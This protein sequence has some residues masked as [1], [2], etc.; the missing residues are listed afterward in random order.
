M[1][2]RSLSRRLTTCAGIVTVLA[3]VYFGG[4][5]VSRYFFFRE[6]DTQ[7]TRLNTAPN[8]LAQW[9][10]EQIDRGFFN[11]TLTLVGHPN[12]EHLTTQLSASPSA[13]S[14]VQLASSVLGNVTVTLPIVV[15]HG[16]WST[17]Y[18]GT[19][20]LVIDL[21]GLGRIN[22]LQALTKGVPITVKGVL[23][24]YSQNT[25]N[26][27]SLPPLSF[28]GIFALEGA[29]LQGA[30]VS[31]VTNGVFKWTSLS[32]G[33]LGNWAA[34][35]EGLDTGPVELVMSEKKSTTTSR[36][37]QLLQAKQVEWRQ[38]GEHLKA[39]QI[40]MEVTLL[41]EEAAVPSRIGITLDQ[42]SV[43]DSAP[44]Q[45][46]AIV[47]LDPS[48]LKR[49]AAVLNAWLQYQNAPDAGT[50]EHLREAMIAL[51]RKAPT[52]SLD[53]L[54]VDG[55]LLLD[56]TAL[57][58]TGQ[59]SI[60]AGAIADTASIEDVLDHLRARLDTPQLPR[61]LAH[62]LP[63]VQPEHPLHLEWR[64]ENGLWINDVHSPR[65]HE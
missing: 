65:V 14:A 28:P 45:L 35:I 36:F 61:A 37:E 63:E 26:V 34:G 13:L 30:R 8:S 56:P 55:S 1:T 16:W 42:L 59:M 53:A 18:D 49:F 58:A 32:V 22:P 3:G 51:A 19:L 21:P 27:V 54:Y 41:P 29:A 11:S 33:H 24:H 17:G 4:L 7:I 25:D 5:W 43:D 15:H 44:G 64:G 10:V 2:A 12:A 23:Q 60:D 31:G 50:H 46:R 6:L 39:G 47:A 62:W 48:N 20:S 57:Q 38:A 40:S 9:R 52:V